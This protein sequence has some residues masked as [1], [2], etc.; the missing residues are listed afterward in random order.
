[1]YAHDNMMLFQNLK[2]VLKWVSLEIQDMQVMTDNECSTY[3]LLRQDLRENGII[4]LVK[5][6]RCNQLVGSEYFRKVNVR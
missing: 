5:V 2:Y 1:M 6:L 4:P 3:M